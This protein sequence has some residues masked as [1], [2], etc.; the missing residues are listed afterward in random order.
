MPKSTK[1]TSKTGKASKAPKV[2]FGAK[3]AFVRSVAVDVPAS[4][5]V[6]LAKK[7][8]LA[9]SENHV[10]NIRATDR[11]QATKSGKVPRAVKSGRPSTSNE[12]SLYAEQFR[13]AVVKIGFIEAEKIWEN[14]RVVCGVNSDEPAPTVR[15]RTVVTPSAVMGGTAPSPASTAPSTTSG[16]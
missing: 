2:E 13:T 10:Y 11:K 5:V 6:A 12:A 15:R 9:L 7:Q 14:L 3:S 4:E 16:E 8:G 1:R